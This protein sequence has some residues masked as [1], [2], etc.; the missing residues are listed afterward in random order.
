[1]KA[2]GHSADS[3]LLKSRWKG[4][5]GVKRDP[6]GEKS[7]VHVCILEKSFKNSD[8]YENFPALCRIKFVKIG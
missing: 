6:N 5:G 3:S 8:L 2:Y 7:R 1:M 4:G